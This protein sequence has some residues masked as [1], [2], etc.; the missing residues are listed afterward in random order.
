MMIEHRAVEY[1]EKFEIPGATELK[2]ARQLQLAAAELVDQRAIEARRR[3][4][5]WEV[6]GETLGMT[7]QGALRRY[8]D[9]VK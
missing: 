5:T 4:V 9:Q 1:A 6:I 3:G 7:R 2:E 8:G